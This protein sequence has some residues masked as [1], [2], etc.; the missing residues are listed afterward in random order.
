MKEKC[1]RCGGEIITVTRKGKRI[2]FCIN[3]G[4]EF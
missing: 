2:R 4:M 1:R 3:C